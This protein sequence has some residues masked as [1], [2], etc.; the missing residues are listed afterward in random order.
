MTKKKK[1]LLAVSTVLIVTI[2]TG[3]LIAYFA[4]KDDEPNLITVGEDDIEVTE[5]FTPPK[6]TDEFKYRKLVKIK[7]TGSIPCYVRVRL[8]FSNSDVEGVASFSAANQG[9]NDTEP[10]DNTFKSAQ[11]KKG[12]NYYINNLPDGWVYVWEESTVDPIVTNGYYYYTKAIDPNEETNALI[13]WI[14]MDYDST[15]PSAHDVFVYS[16]SV[17]TVDPNTGTVYTDWK[18]AWNSFG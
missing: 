14:K 16:E 2:I 5:V 8:E 10:D 3:V 4:N 17:Q 12:T 1:M 13:S 7:N 9:D 15:L 6:Q 11:I 18:A